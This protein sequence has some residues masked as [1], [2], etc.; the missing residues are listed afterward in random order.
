MNRTIEKAEQLAAQFNGDGTTFTDKKQ[1]IEQA[2]IIISS[3]GS[4]E[5]ILHQDDVIKASKKRKGR[6]LFIVDIAVPR[7]I[8]PEIHNIEGVFLY[9]IDDLEGIVHA[10]LAERKGAALEIEKMI[11]KQMAAYQQ[12]LDLLGVVPVMNALRQKSLK[13]QAET[14]QSIERKLPGLSEREKKVLSKHT[15]SI[16]NQM[17]RE[18]I[19]KMK[20]MAGNPDRDQMLEMFTDI[21]G[22][23]EELALETSKEEKRDVPDK[24]ADLA[25]HET[26]NAFS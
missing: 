26:L 19:Q 25:K 12:W 17:L 3:T 21:F 20:E 5:Y 9:D 2:D 8:D 11:L 4:K 6:P 7:D 23:D 18:P 22:I 1:K 15:K 16:V 13:I 10:N 24:T 14:M